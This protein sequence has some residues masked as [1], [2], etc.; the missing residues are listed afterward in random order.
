[1]YTGA[2]PTEPL[3][4]APIAHDSILLSHAVKTPRAFLLL[5]GLTASP[6]QFAS[7][8]QLLHERGSNVY[9]PRLPRHGLADR[10]TAE[11]AGLTAGELTAFAVDAARKAAELGDELT[12][13][14]FSVGGLL[15]AWIGQHLEVARCVCIAPFLG[16]AWLPDR[17][18]PGLI[19]AALRAP[20]QFWWWDP[21]LRERMLPDHGYPRF[22]THAVARAANMAGELLRDAARATPAAGEVAI[23]VNGSEM[24]VS[25]PAARRLAALW[26]ARAPDRTS[27]HRL[28]GLPRSH[29]IIEPLRSPA[30]ARAVYPLLLGLVDR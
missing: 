24:T 19:R 4:P 2:T 11:L 17:A 3:E 8:G 10:L 9:I 26:A 14:G 25:N 29:D 16:L 5:H 1:M 7:F 21:R 13:V 22:S 23:V 30:V 20:N 27:L 28:H 12:V 15:S 6:R 18:L